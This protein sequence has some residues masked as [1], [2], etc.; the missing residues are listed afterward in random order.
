MI[1]RSRG[2]AVAA[3]RQGKARPVLGASSHKTGV[4]IIAS[5]SNR[6]DCAFDDVRVPRQDA[7]I[8]KA[9]QRIP[10]AQGVGNGFTECRARQDARV[11]AVEPGTKVLEQRHG[12]VL[13]R[14]PPL[15]ESCKLSGV[16]PYAYLRDVLRRIDGH[17]IDWPAELLPL[18]WKPLA[19]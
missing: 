10:V 8:G 1:M 3:L 13:P 2:D 7:R 14:L 11:V 5:D 18:N 4:R 6:A 17:C 12:L 19:T 15:I 9:H 16:K